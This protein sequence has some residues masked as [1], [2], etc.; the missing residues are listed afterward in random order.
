MVSNRPGASCSPAGW[1]T[2]TLRCRG[3]HSWTCYTGLRASTGLTRPQSPAGL[4]NESKEELWRT[5]MA[6]ARKELPPTA[7]NL[8]VIITGI[9]KSFKGGGKKKKMH[10][11]QSAPDHISQRRGSSP[12]MGWSQGR[13]GECLLWETSRNLSPS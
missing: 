6:S 11:S 5:K 3:R 8:T 2:T 12:V 9:T 4:R 13:M 1:C 7:R 10:L